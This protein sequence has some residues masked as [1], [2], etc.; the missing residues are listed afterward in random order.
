MVLWRKV[1]ILQNSV[2]SPDKNNMKLIWNDTRMS[3]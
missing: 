3:K 1:K 2:A